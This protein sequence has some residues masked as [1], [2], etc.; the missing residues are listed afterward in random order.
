LTT[1][2]VTP[3]SS[4]ASCNALTAV[5]WQLDDAALL[6]YFAASDE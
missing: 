4:V 1:A 5:Q 2:F 6:D 3:G